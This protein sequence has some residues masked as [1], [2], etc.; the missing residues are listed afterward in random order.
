MPIL[1]EGS[2]YHWY[3]ISLPF[4]QKIESMTMVVFL[5]KETIKELDTNKFVISLECRYVCEIVYS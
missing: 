3:R 5:T 4:D 2:R 1:K